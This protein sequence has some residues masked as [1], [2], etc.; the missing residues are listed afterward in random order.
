L[1]GAYRPLPGFGVCPKY[2]FFFVRVQEMED[3]MKPQ[4]TRRNYSPSRKVISMFTNLARLSQRAGAV[5]SSPQEIERALANVLISQLVSYCKARQGA[6]LLIMPSCEAWPP[7]TIASLAHQEQFP[8]VSCSH[9]DRQTLLPYLALYQPGGA[10][11]QQPVDA[12]DMVIWR[13]TLQTL[14]WDNQLQ[15]ERCPSGTETRNLQ[16]LPQ[17]LLLFVWSGIGQGV[18]SELIDRAIDHLSPIADAVDAVIINMQLALR[19]HDLNQLTQ[20]KTEYHLELLKAELMATV[21]HELRSPLASIKGYAT[22]LLRHDHRISREERHEFLVAISGASTRLQNAID[23]LLE[24]SQLETKT[25]AFAPVPVNL[26]YLAREAVIASEQPMADKHAPQAAKAILSTFP[27]EQ[28]MPPSEQDKVIVLGDR[29]LLRKMLDGLLENARHYSALGGRIE[30]G[31]QSLAGDHIYTYFAHLGSQ[32][33]QARCIL[34]LPYGGEDLPL[35]EVWVKDDGIGIAPEHL[36][37]IFDRFYRV[38]TSL[39]REVNGLGLGLALCKHIIEL[40]QGAIWVES[41]VGVGSTFHIF[42]PQQPA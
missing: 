17:A 30:V 27:I 8:F 1:Q 12:P 20:R 24:L 14:V 13:R 33:A 34:P 11:I 37:Y 4:Q 26:A 39:T 23:R 32:S 28:E 19:L 6:L 25:I 9:M 35:V 15:E 38:D 36:A 29:L 22:T 41:E 3:Q 10:D 7:T 16:R 2:S 5:F 21:S 40:H 42:L 31:V 18:R